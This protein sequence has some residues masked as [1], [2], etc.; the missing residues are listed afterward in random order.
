MG[1]SV[2]DTIRFISQYTVM[3]LVIHSTRLTL[4]PLHASDVDLVI[5]M[6]SDPEVM[7]YAGGARTEDAIRLD[8]L[9]RTKRG[10]NGC[11]GIWCIS[12]REDGERL[13]T[14]ALLPIPIDDDHT[15]YS[16]VVPG[17]MPQGDIE[18]GY[19]LKR[20]AW[21]KGYATEA[22]RRLL[23]AAFEDSPL[24]E[25]VATFD[26]GNDGSRGVLVK[27]GFVDQGAKW[28]YGELGPFFRITRDDW[29]RRHDGERK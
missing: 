9:N 27:S 10:G 28:T 29:Q 2:T 26:V 13:G 7:K 18:V 8:F 1:N 4:T 12:S 19:Y 11:I 17:K 20:S 14:A 5:E 21:G 24:T 3:N 16:L 23:R 15:D 6:F 25:I 22:C